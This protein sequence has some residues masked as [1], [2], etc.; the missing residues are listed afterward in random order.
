MA[1]IRC[2]ECGTQISDKAITCPR[3]GAPVDA[4]ARRRGCGCGTLLLL[5]AGGG[6]FLFALLVYLLSGEKSKEE[7]ETDKTATS[8]ATPQTTPAATPEPTPVAPI[9][10]GWRFSNQEGMITLKGEA[11]NVSGEAIKHVVAVGIFSA[12][13]GSIREEEYLLQPDPMQPGQTSTFEIKFKGDPQ[14]QKAD[15]RFKD[16]MGHP[17]EHGRK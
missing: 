16:V 13:D 5:L 15:V 3:C 14:I 6:A 8:T 4:A 7:A 17:I 9:Q 10:A 2:A 12:P 11:K 1:L